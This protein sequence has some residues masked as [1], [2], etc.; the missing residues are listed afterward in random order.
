MAGLKIKICG[1]R[2]P[3]NISEISR[4]LPDYMGFIF[5]SGSKRYA[6]EIS[7]DDL[8]PL[9]AQ[10]RRVG[11]FVDRA[12]GDVLSICS[13]LG[14][15]TVQLHGNESPSYCRL[16]IDSGL[17]VIKVLHIGSDGGIDPAG[18]YMDSCDFFLL[19]TEGPGYGGTGEKFNWDLIRDY[20]LD[21]PF[22][23]SGGIGPKDADRIMD[24]KHPRFYGV[25]VNSRFEIRP[26][27]KRR[28]ELEAF[29]RKLRNG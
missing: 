23:L 29:I 20:N 21:K 1:M 19:D 18:P 26:G 5:Y 10:V 7:S 28:D 16:M 22:F 4:L 3:G 24:L 8:S 12:G 15:K 17:E 9:P 2:D 13:R 14:I 25:D 27:I 11:V 6:G